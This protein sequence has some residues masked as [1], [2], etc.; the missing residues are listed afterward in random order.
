MQASDG[1]Q[2]IKLRDLLNHGEVTEFAKKHRMSRQAAG[3][4]IKKE[5]P[6]HPVVKTAWARVKEDGR[7]ERARGL[8]SLSLM[9]SEVS[10]DSTHEE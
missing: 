1:K 5:S 6:G 9:E 8:S 3:K 4:A 10:Q 2:L 7:L